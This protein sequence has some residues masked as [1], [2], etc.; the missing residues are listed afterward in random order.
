MSTAR[1]QITASTRIL[2]DSHYGAHLGDQSETVDSALARR[3]MQWLIAPS[4]KI[5]ILRGLVVFLIGRSYDL[6]V[7][8]LHAHGGL[9]LLIFQAWFCPK[10]PR[11]M[12]T[13]FITKVGFGLRRIL[14]LVVLFGKTYGSQAR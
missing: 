5:G 4:K 2:G 12:F 13:E 8:S 1:L 7:T 10:V 3:G 14:Y 9:S 11:L 6:I